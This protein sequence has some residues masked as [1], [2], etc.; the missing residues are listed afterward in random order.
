MTDVEGRPVLPDIDL[1]EAIVRTNL[2]DVWKGFR[3]AD[4]AAVVVKFAT[5][6]SGPDMLRQE[7]KTVG[8]LRAAG[9]GGIIP[10]EYRDEPRP[11]LV[12]PWKGALTMRDVLN[13]IRG[14]DDRSRATDMFLRLVDVVAKVHRAGFLHGDLKPENVIVDAE[15]GPWLTDFGMARVIRTARLDTHVSLSMSRSEKEWGGTLRY[16]PPEGLQGDA[17]SRTWDVYALGVILHEILLGARPD[18]A[19]TPENLKTL[20]PEEVVRTL[21]DALAY[22]SGDRLP[23]AGALLERLDEIRQELTSR[24]PAR[25]LHRGLRLGMTVLGAFAVVLRYGSVLALLLGYAATLYWIPSQPA[26]ILVA[27]PA[28]MLH[29]TVRWEGPE[30]LEESRLRKRGGVI[31]R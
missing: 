31:G 23:T 18:R 5:T 9:I 21:L 16:L 14:G 20:L 28:V 12:L 27:I 15:G 19:A 13:G 17:P 8:D 1:A 22:A 29:M 24:G 4:G 3:R 2:S 11:H 25:W 30:T 6:S 10:A 7:A 26:A